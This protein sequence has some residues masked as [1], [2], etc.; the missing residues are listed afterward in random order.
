MLSEYYKRHFAILFTMVFNKESM[1]NKQMRYYQY[2]VEF[3]KTVTIKKYT[4]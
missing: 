4:N 3:F 1:S 2:L